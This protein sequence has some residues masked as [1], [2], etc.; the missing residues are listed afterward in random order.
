[1]IVIISG[2]NRPF[3]NSLKISRIV[4]SIVLAQGRECTVLDLAELPPELFAPSSYMEKPAGFNRF[5]NAIL[6]AEGIL[7]I[8]PEYNGAYPGVLKYFIDMLSFP[9]S[10]VEKPAAF[11]G[12]SAGQWGATRAVEQLEMVFQYR[13]AH[14]YGRRVFIP[15]IQ[16]EL[17]DAGELKNLDLRSRLTTMVDGFGK[18]CTD[19]GGQQ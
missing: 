16:G 6:G 15:G 12:I 1:M 11:V 17:D 8:V 13:C 3:S 9:D 5:Q 7:S 2:T 4:E 14:L 19:I 10:L 18:F